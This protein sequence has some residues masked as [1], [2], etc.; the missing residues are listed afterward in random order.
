MFE[1][2]SFVESLVDQ[3]EDP[4]DLLLQTFVVRRRA[5][6]CLGLDLGMAVIARVM[7]ARHSLESLPHAGA[8]LVLIRFDPGAG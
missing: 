3:V 6:R 5:M 2:G 7:F 4:L 8:S 1:I